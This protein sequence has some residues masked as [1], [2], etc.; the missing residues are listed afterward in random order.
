M[1]EEKDAYSSKDEVR[2]IDVH[3]G[4]EGTNSNGHGEEIVKE[5]NMMKIINNLQ[6]DVQMH[7]ADKKSLMR[8]KEQQ[9]YFNMK[10]MQSPEIIENKLDKESGSIKLENHGTPDEE[11]RGRSGRRNQQNSKRN[12]KRYYELE[13]IK[14]YYHKKMKE[15]FELKLGSMSIYEY[16][17]RFFELLKYVPFIKD[18]TIK[19]QRYLSGLPSSISDK[20]QYD[21]PKTMEETIRREK[22][23]Y[24][25][26]KENPIFQKSWEDKKFKREQMQEGKKSPFFRNIPQGQPVLREPGMGE[27]CGKRP[28]LTPMECWGCKGYNMYRDC[29]HRMLALDQVLR[30]L[31]QV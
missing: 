7:Q 22:C 24:D 8:A 13:S 29:P 25:Q 2:R 16:E 14:R 27:L 9:G 6:K 15:L 3:L 11:R 20:I 23:L 21:D 18:D 31:G 4:I 30:I 5:V 12:T 10:L 19:I 17:R 26:Q 28:R 1:E